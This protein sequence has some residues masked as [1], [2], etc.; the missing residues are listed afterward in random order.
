MNCA[1]CKY[2]S[3]LLGFEDE[4]NLAQESHHHHVEGLQESCKLCESECTGDCESEE[5][6]SG[7]NQAS[8][9]ENHSHSHLHHPYPNAEHP[10]GP[11]SL[12]NYNTFKKPEGK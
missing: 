2:R 12:R 5:N 4:V 10:L 1:L 3:S 9:R 7:L 6:H 11:L 8:E